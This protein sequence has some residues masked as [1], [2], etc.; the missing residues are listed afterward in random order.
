MAVNFV[1]AVARLGRVDDLCVEFLESR[2]HLISNRK[3]SPLYLETT[4]F[5]FNRKEANER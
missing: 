3:L 1:R 5:K 2:E 4:G